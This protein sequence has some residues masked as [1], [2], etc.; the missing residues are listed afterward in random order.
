MTKK[1]SNKNVRSRQLQ[2]QRRAKAHSRQVKANRTSPTSRIPPLRGV[3]GVFVRGR[4]TNTPLTPLK[5]G[6]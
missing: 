3:R 5:G 2:E 6:T 4:N 1:L